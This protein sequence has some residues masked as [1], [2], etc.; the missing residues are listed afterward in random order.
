[1]I[2]CKIFT[3]QNKTELRF[4]QRHYVISPQRSC[5]HKC[6]SHKSYKKHVSSIS[7]ISQQWEA[8][9]VLLQDNLDGHHSIYS[10][11]YYKT[12]C[13]I[14]RCPHLVSV[15]FLLQ[16]GKTPLT[17]ERTKSEMDGLRTYHVCD[18]LLVFTL[19]YPVYTSTI[20]RNRFRSHESVHTTTFNPDQRFDL[21]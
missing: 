21:D 9:L 14:F 8:Y 1:M 20:R 10:Y 19:Q 17:S 16:L 2:L 13:K 4:N 15:D 18:C 3:S 11:Y 12:I 7:P 5:Y 6:R